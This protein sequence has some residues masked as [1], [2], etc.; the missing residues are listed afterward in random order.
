MDVIRFGNGIDFRE[1]FDHHRHFNIDE[2]DSDGNT[3]LMIA[4]LE[5]NLEATKCLI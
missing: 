1:M 2:Q 3:L 5:G 4:C